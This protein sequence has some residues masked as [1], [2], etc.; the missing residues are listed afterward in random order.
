[1]S[2]LTLERQLPACSASHIW[3]TCVCL[4]AC[5]GNPRRANTGTGAG[6]SE[7][8]HQSSI[9]KWVGA[10]LSKAAYQEHIRGAGILGPLRHQAMTGWTAAQCGVFM[11]IDH[12]FGA[13]PSN[14][15]SHVSHPSTQQVLRDYGN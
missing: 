12:P 2:E 10:S 8:P 15:V 14:A 4:S 9:R 3:L 11:Q 5:G 1:M 7:E 6:T 13:R